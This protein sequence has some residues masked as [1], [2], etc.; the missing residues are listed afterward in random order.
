VRASL[1]FYA[2][3]PNYAFIL[4]EAGF[5]GTTARIR[6]KQNAGDFNGMASQISN[7]TLQPLPPSRRGRAWPMRSSTS[8]KESPVAS[9][10]I[11]RLPIPSA[12]SDMV[13]WRDAYRP[14]NRASARVAGR[15]PTA[16][17]PYYVGSMSLTS[18]D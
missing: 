12:P 4:D 14:G 5:D 18:R 7:D 9:F 13:R 11:T 2:N 16:Q 3:T 6:E 17:Q 8:T 15:Q 1:S 10:C